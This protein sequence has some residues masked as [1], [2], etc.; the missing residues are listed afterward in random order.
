MPV[1]SIIVAADQNKA[2]GKNNSLP[3]HLPNDLKFFKNKTMGHHMIM[4][5]K[6]L[7]SIGKLLPGRTSVVISRQEDYVFDGAEVVNSIADAL[8]YVAEHEKEEAFVI[9]GAEIINQMI[10]YADT[11]YYTDVKTIIDNADVFLEN[12]RQDQWLETSRIS[13]E[14][15]ENHAFPYDFVTYQRK[16]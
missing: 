3:W 7:E 15:D 14:A 13:H 2:I 5:R 11:M 16:R 1:I 4:G 9:G 12:F 10:S 8:T 6:T